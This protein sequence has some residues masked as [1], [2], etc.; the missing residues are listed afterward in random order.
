MNGL[1]CVGLLLVLAPFM[2]SLPARA[3]DDVAGSDESTVRAAYLYNFAKFTQW[4][5][6]PRARFR[7]CVL[8]DEVFDRAA[9]SLIGKPLRAMQISVRHGVSL[10]DIPQCD[11]VFVPAGHDANLARVR[12]A[13]S[14]YPILIVAESSD[15]LPK[16]ALVAMI[17]S[18]DHIVFEVDLTAAR[19][20]GLQV[21]AKM[22][23]LAR[24]V[25]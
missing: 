7:L 2:A 21:S 6:E 15:V 13:V 8:G 16:G 14:G 25:Y 22:L 5:D 20:L 17:R 18:D 9:D 19:Q 12:E 23:Q 11:L 24:K 1:A 10:Q 4:P 3:A